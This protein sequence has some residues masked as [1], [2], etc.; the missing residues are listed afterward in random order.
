MVA[1]TAMRHLLDLARGFSSELAAA[2]VIVIVVMTVRVGIV[3]WFECEPEDAATGEQTAEGA[4]P[5]VVD[6]AVTDDGQPRR[7][8]DRPVARRGQMHVLGVA[9]LRNLL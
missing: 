9:L 7:D 2:V 4:Q 3:G 6:E 1:A 5:E 8:H